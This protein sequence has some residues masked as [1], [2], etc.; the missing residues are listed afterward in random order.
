MVRVNVLSPR[1]ALDLNARELIHSDAFFEEARL[2]HLLFGGPSENELL[3]RLEA[4]GQAGDPAF[5]IGGEGNL[6]FELP[7]R[8][9]A[10]RSKT[11]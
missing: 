1:R 9:R 11:S 2:N 8:R 5:Q 3:A 7:A 6:L 4:H 10:S